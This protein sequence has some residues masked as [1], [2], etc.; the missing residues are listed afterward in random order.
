MKVFTT[1]TGF[2][3]LNEKTI[4][5]FLGKNSKLICQSQ[6]NNNKSVKY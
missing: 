4:Q 6:N 3:S 1:I 5:Q 2:R